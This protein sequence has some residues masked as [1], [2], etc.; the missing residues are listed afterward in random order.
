[1]HDTSRRKRVKKNNKRDKNKK[2]VCYKI[3]ADIILLHF[4]LTQN[5][6]QFHLVNCLYGQILVNI[7][8]REK[9]LSLGW[10]AHFE[11]ILA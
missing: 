8:E 11:N 4:C 1:M 2:N 6:L 9:D 7:N 3:E 5:F 10:L